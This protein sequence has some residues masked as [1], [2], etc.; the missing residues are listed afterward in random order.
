[1]GKLGHFSLR[2]R[3]STPRIVL[4]LARQKVR[5]V[6]P[7][8]PSSALPTRT[9]GPFHP[10]KPSLTYGDAVK[11]AELLSGHFQ[12]AGQFLDVGPWTTASPSRGFANW[13]HRFDW[14][15][16]LLAV[17]SEAH[18]AKA[19]T[20]VDEWIDTYSR[21]NDFIFEPDRLA[22]R[23]FN[24]LALWSP[25]LSATGLKD[26]DMGRGDSS[27]ALDR[28]RTSV[29]SQL[30]AL[31]GSLK[32]LPVGLPRLTAGCALAMGGA[33]LA[34]G[35]NTFLERGLALLDLE[36][37]LQILPDG[38][39]ISRSPEVTA[40]A[41]RQL[42]ILDTLL[43][44]RGL[45]GS[46]ELSRAIDRLAPMV[47]F[48][49][50]SGGALAPFNGG[51]EMKAVDISN[52]LRA[53]PGDAKAFGYGPHSGYQRLEAHGTVALLDTGEA[54]PHPFDTSAHLAPLA[55]DLSTPEGPI[56]TACGFNPEQPAEW[57][58]SVR[59][60][61]AHSTLV[62][63]NHS[64]GRLLKSDWRRGVI[65]DAVEHV[66][67]P[68]KVTRKEQ[69]G[70]IWIE[71]HHEG[72]LEEYGL[73]HRRRIFMPRDGHD[74]RG[75]DSLYTP[76]GSI[77]PRRDQVRF[78]I[79]FHLHPSVQV[80][81]SQDRSSALIVVNGKAGW[82]FRTDGGKVSLEDSV[83]LAVGPTPVK[84]QQ[85]VILGRAYCDSDGE[86]RSNRIRWSFRK[87]KPASKDGRNS[88]T[89]KEPELPMSDEESHESL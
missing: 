33:R 85:L 32:T 5:R 64:P 63:D 46:R 4:D 73:S 76:M 2:A 62:L 80:S 55:L 16:D 71:S 70:G 10:A 47:A 48:F 34:E 78:A 14:L 36:L 67:G 19:R 54:P 17:D 49:S 6:L 8:R 11:G 83:Y 22:H 23:L 87:L 86:S 20:L 39:H 15:H 60:A 28:R 21:G 9:P 77:P 41:L 24:W 25:A 38:G 74:V 43:A 66:A 72:Y 52:L 69:D 35:K 75:E 29:L 30:N 7:S 13:L 61:A 44:E 31:R 45:E 88:V 84:T 65:G 59:S 58:R 1:M 56:I 89:Q 12:F 42:L 26:Q 79:R 27:G 82:R 40:I 81:L 51:G 3:L 68:V 18:H 37:P 50:R 53:A 57:A